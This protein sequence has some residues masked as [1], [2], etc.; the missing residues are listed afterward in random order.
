MPTCRG[1]QTQKK[2]RKII[3]YKSPQRVNKTSV[4]W[5]SDVNCVEKFVKFIKNLWKT[6][7]L[8]LGWEDGSDRGAN[9]AN[10]NMPMMQVV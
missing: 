6:R 3:R 5:D 9:E 2:E 8:H 4:R 1:W 10:R 7:I